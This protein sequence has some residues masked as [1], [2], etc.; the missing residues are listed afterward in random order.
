MVRE[1]CVL[2]CQDN[3]IAADGTPTTNASKAAPDNI[4]LVDAVHGYRHDRLTRQ[5]EEAAAWQVHLQSAPAPRL[6]VHLLSWAV[7][8]HRLSASARA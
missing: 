5:F 4:Y 7:R 6:D 3:R 2:A 8:S 1:C